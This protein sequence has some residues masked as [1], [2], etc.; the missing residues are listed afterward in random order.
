MLFRN[1]PITND[2]T[3]DI[4]A[5]NVQLQLNIDTSQTGRTFQDR[6]HLFKLEP[7]PTDVPT[8]SIIHNVNVRG[9]RGNI[10]QT[11]PA[12]EYDFS[13]TNLVMSKEDLVQIQWTGIL[14]DLFINATFTVESL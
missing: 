11:F 9:K 12:V 8:N 2:P 10:A 3:V 13:P 6:S 1:S 14:I 5:L 4:G 7:R